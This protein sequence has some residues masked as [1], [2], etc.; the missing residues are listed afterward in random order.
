MKRKGTDIPLA[1][2]ATP[3]DLRYTSVKMTKRII[4]LNGGASL[5]IEENKQVKA[6]YPNGMTDE[7]IKVWL[8]SQKTKP[9]L[10]AVG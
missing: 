4:V 2:T 10:R 6:A 1:A 7:D 5:S 8:D 9:Q 3:E